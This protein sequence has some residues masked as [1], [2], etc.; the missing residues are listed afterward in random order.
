MLLMFTMSQPKRGVL[1]KNTAHRPA[2]ARPP[3]AS[4]PPAVAEEQTGGKFCILVA[5]RKKPRLPV[6]YQEDV[7]ERCEKGKV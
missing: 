1:V 2:L 4:I 3:G 6:R 7:C 5:G